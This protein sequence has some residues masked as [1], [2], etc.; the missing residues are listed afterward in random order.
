MRFKPLNLLTVRPVFT[1]T[2]LR[3]L[4]LL[5]LILWIR[6]AI[7]T[8][9]ASWQSMDSLWADFLHALPLI[10]VS[11]LVLLVQRI[12]LEVAYVLLIGVEVVGPTRSHSVRALRS[13]VV[14][15]PTFTARGL[16]LVWLAVLIVCLFT[17]G[18]GVWTLTALDWTGFSGWS[19]HDYLVF[20]L[21][22]RPIAE[23]ALAR[24]AVEVATRVLPAGAAV[25]PATS[26]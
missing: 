5:L 18:E 15:R 3:V 13:V 6:R 21:V 22:L 24:V 19:T 8:V 4:W 9:L 20:W 1:A 25:E 23:L 17:L 2:G 11:L 14:L 10:A 16:R 12:L 26:R 7:G